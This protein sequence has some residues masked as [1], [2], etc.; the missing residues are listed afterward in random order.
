MRL[1]ITRSAVHGAVAT[2]EGGPEVF[3]IVYA[4]ALGGDELG[5]MVDDM[6][7]KPHRRDRSGVRTGFYGGEAILAGPSVRVGP[8]SRVCVSLRERG[9]RSAG[10]VG[11]YLHIDRL[12]LWGNSTMHNPENPSW[13]SCC[14]M[15]AGSALFHLANG[16]LVETGRLAESMKRISSA[17]NNNV[18]PCTGKKTVKRL[19]YNLKI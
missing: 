18:I 9:H 5:R 12:S 4:K 2:L 6:P 17:K 3:Y 15:H 7:C 19:T 11:D 8:T 13:V 16:G 10:S 14:A 1:Q